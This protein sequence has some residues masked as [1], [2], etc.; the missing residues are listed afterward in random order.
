MD[1][2]SNDVNK[3]WVKYRDVVIEN[4]ITDKYADYYVKWAQK[5]ALSIKGKPLIKRS[6]DDIKRFIDKV[7]NEKNVQE[8]LIKEESEKRKYQRADIRGRC[9]RKLKSD[10]ERQKRAFQRRTIE[11]RENVKADRSG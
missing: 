8:W 6:L 1:K 9:I 4:G 3:F 10:A 5:F 2:N 11:T 7:K